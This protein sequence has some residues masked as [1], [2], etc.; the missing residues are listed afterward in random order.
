MPFVGLIATALIFTLLHILLK[1][2]PQ[3]WTTGNQTE[4]IS[5]VPRKGKLILVI[6]MLFLIA[7]RAVDF[8]SRPPQVEISLAKAP[9]RYAEGFIVD[10]VKWRENFLDY[11]LAFKNLEPTLELMDLRIDVQFPAGVVNS[12]VLP[13]KGVEALH[14]APFGLTAAQGNPKGERVAPLTAYRTNLLITAVRVFPTAE[15]TTRIILMDPFAGKIV[16]GASDLAK[17][18]CVSYYYDDF[19]DHKVKWSTCYPLVKPENTSEL[20]L[21]IDT[22]NPIPP[23]TRTLG[24]G[25][26]FDQPQ[27]VKGL[28]T[29]LSPDS[30]SKGE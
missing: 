15:F 28:N 3:T 12:T 29:I 24:R 14:A 23:A 11:R 27:T 8:V 17:D 7:P 9:G 1:R 20:L 13:S 4:V 18:L 6:L 2:F 21:S 30:R 10:G 5:S 19:W 22:A 25:I 16:T 26:V